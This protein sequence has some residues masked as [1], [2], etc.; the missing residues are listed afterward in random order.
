MQMTLRWYGPDDPVTLQ[1]IRQIPGV[2]GIVSALHDIPT[3]EVWPVERIQQRKDTIEAAGLEWSVVESINLHDSIKRAGPERDQMIEIYQQSI[4]NMGQVGIKTLCYNFMPVFDWMRTELDMPMPDGSTALNYNHAQL[5]GLDMVEHIKQLP[6]WDKVFTPEMMAEMKAAYAEISTEQ[7]LE[8]LIYFLK[9]VVPVAEEAGVYMGIHPDDPPWPVFGLPRV[10]TNA[11]NIRAFLEAVPSQHNG[12]TF[13]TGSLGASAAND[14]PAMAR[15]FVDRINFMHMRNV[16][17]T[18]EFD[19][20]ESEHPSEFGS[21]DMRGVMSAL[22]DAGYTGPIRPDHG[23]MIWGEEGR[24]GYG[25]Y[26][27]ALGAM[28]L[29]GLYEG[30]QS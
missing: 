12:L 7:L 20:H 14:L 9:A 6:A 1:N 19:F 13:C 10:V 21:V 30:L 28:Y 15:E 16:R 17:R 25:L 5:E 18:G 8:N 3:D 2:T 29:R 26:D 23:R 4:R 22:V 11:E 27:R 24:A